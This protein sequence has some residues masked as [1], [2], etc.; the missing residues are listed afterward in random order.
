[1]EQ[2]QTL[3]LFVSVDFNII[4]GP[5]GFSGGAVVNNLAY[6]V[7]DAGD[8]VRSLGPEKIP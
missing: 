5:S 1:M 4:T 2:T 6:S 8:M 7:P 3:L